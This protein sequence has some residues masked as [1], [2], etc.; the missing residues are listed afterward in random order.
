MEAQLEICEEMEGITLASE[1]PRE[2]TGEDMTDNGR[3]HFTQK[4][5]NLIGE[6]AGAHAGKWVKALE[7]TESKR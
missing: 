3:I 6:D 5:L 2:L 1:L 7:K 4:A